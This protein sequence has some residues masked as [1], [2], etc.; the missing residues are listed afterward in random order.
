[1]LFCLKPTFKVIAMANVPS[2]GFAS[3]FSEARKSARLSVADIAKRMGISI[4]SVYGWEKGSVPK[5]DRMNE[6]ADMFDVPVQWL[7]FGEGEPHTLRDE[8]GDWSVPALRVTASAGGGALV[9]LPSVVS[10]MSVNPV[11]VRQIYPGAHRDSLRIVTVRGQSMEPTYHNDDILLVD[12]AV[13]YL[14]QEGYYVLSYRGLTYVKKLQPEPGDKLA[15]ISDNPEYKSFVVDLKDESTQIEIHGLVI[16]SW[17]GT[18][19]Y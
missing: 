11:F 19:R 2:S 4:Q 14:I 3:R 9:E 17:T 10:L 7:A 1:M 13:T 8:N 6:L 5:A 18:K 15:I 12:T 16:Y